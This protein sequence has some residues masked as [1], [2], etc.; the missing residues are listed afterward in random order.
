MD[1][2]ALFYTTSI[3]DLLGMSIS[4]WLALYLLG[5]GFTNRLTLHAV[6]ALVSMAAFFLGAYLN[7]FQQTP[8]TAAWRA[9]LLIIALT[10]WYSLTY[11]LLPM[12]TKGKLRWLLLSICAL[13]LVTLVLLTTDRSAFI[14]EPGNQFWVGRMGIGF[15]YLVYGIT[16]LALAGAILYNFLSDKRIGLSPQNRFFFIASLF[17][18][19]TVGYGI[20]ALALTPPM[21]RFVQDGLIFCGIFLLGISAARHQT[22]IGRRTILHD[23]PLSGLTLLGLAAIYA[24]LA[25]RWGFAPETVAA[26]LT[27]AILT[28]SVYDLAREIL[29]RIRHR[30][31]SVFRQHLRRLEEEAPSNDELEEHLQGGLALLCQTLNA[32]GGFIA[33]RQG[34]QFV[35][36]SSHHSLSLGR[37][38][39]ASEIACD[40]ICQPTGALAEEIA[41]LASASEA[42]V[43]LTVVGIGFPKARPDYSSD[44]LDLLAEFADRV[45]SIVYLYGL[46][47]GKRAQLRHL[48]E[49]VRSEEADLIARTQ[50]L[51]ATAVTVP[52]PQLVKLVEEGL[53][54]LPDTITLAETSLAEWLG[55][56]N[57]TSIERGKTIQQRLYQAIETL[58]PGGN[59]PT[60]PLPREWYNY[61]VLHDAYVEGMPNREIMARLYISEGTFNR[62]RRNALRGL[63]R[64]LAEERQSPSA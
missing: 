17:P 39:L 16:Q 8:G 38:L 33:I 12:P 63:A 29:E 35:I 59:R 56:H 18:I 22:L 49:E 52:D 36:I 45:A 61:V 60:E 43:Q 58:R 7:I 4:L 20:L 32:S 23:L 40:D 42:N 5:R 10:T 25:W 24:L 41:W 30:Q 54:H 57:V 28:H 55:I 34:E 11:Q 2:M 15:P 51:V 19:A 53:R 13:S 21:P 46:R 27:L 6:V 47:H 14:A 48:A 3:V 37:E 62:T 1:M 26:I 64:L 44:D 50:D 9:V 31:E